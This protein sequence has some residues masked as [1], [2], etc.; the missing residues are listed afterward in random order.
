MGN[1]SNGSSG[2]PLFSGGA[3]DFYQ[4]GTL[5]SSSAPEYTATAIWTSILVPASGTNHGD[6][7][8]LMLSAFDGQYYYDQIGLS[9]D[10]G[11]PSGCGNPDNTWTVAYEQGSYGTDSAGV[12]CC[13]CVGTFNRDQANGQLYPNSWYTFEMVLSDGKLNFYVWEGKDSFNV[14]VWGLSLPD[15]ATSFYLEPYS[16]Y[17]NGGPTGYYYDF[18]LYNEV[19]YVHGNLSFP[20]WNFRFFNTTI[21]TY[22][23]D[24]TIM[25]PNSWWM[26]NWTAGFLP[27]YGQPYFTS[28]DQGLYQVEI[29][30]E[31]YRIS[32]AS[33]TCSVMPGGNCDEAGYLEPAGEFA[34]TDYCV[35]HS[36]WLTSTT[37]GAPSGWSSYCTFTDPVPTSIVYDSIYWSVV[38]PS[39]IAPGIYYGGVDVAVTLPLSPFSSGPSYVYYIDNWVFDIDVT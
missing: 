25:V 37:C 11:C 32:F 23:T 13:G 27:P 39:G 10:Y 9:S 24:Q 21:Y 16:P 8:A 17:C 18:T 14:E 3:G 19:E 38:V 22:V 6:Q 28:F 5:L 36:C 29:I 20:Q 31:V 33:V 34:P 2:T 12:T 26:G 7:F 35:V 15:I 30:D 4:I 1:D